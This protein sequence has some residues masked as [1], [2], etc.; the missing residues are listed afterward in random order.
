[1]SSADCGAARGRQDDG[2]VTSR[3]FWDQLVKRWNVEARAQGGGHRH[4][5]ELDA[6]SKNSAAP[7]ISVPLAR[8]LSTFVQLFLFD[9]QPNDPLRSP[10]R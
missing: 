2:G 6:A 8:A 5:H 7:V 4:G 10:S 1:M 9:M 3:H